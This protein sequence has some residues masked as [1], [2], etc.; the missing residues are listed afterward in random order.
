MSFIKKNIISALGK[1]YNINSESDMNSFDDLWEIFQIGNKYNKVNKD[2][3][4]NSLQ[5]NYKCLIA[6]IL[7][8]DSFE[9]KLNLS[10]ASKKVTIKENVFGKIKSIPD[11]VNTVIFS[12]HHMT[13]NNHRHNYFSKWNKKLYLELLKWYADKDF[14]LIENGDVEE[15]VIFDPALPDNKIVGRYRNLAK[16]NKDIKKIDWCELVNERIKNRIK[17][18]SK[19]VEDNSDYYNLVRDL[20]IKRGTEYYTKISGNHDPYNSG[21]IKNILPSDMGDH[22][23]DALTIKK[24]SGDES[25]FFV[26]HG[27][28]FDEATLPQHAFA[29]GEVYSES[30]G[31]TIQ[32]ADRIWDHNKTERWTNPDL[33]T[34]FF[35]NQLAIG[36]FNLDKRE[37]KNVKIPGTQIPISDAIIEFLSE[38]LLLGHE[39]AWEY[40]DSKT[41]AGAFQEIFSGDEYLKMRHLS[42]T[43][44][45]NT[46][47]NYSN[48]SDLNKLKYIP[49]VIIG[50]TH[51]PRHNSRYANGKIA[52]NYLNTGSAGR[53]INLIWGI[54]IING[55]PNVISWSNYNFIGNKIKL[56]KYHWKPDT[57]GRLLRREVK[58]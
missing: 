57:K 47:N 4:E 32:G 6:A 52:K 30:V 54:E 50:H 21:K 26:T 9:I 46:Y 14:S 39:V 48:I 34:V 31:W 1:A 16:G 45:V 8:T 42:E 17:I 40:F 28:Q 56:K 7:N 27:H 10:G 36:K 23:Y 20:F 41:K 11:S 19:I 29:I 43:T 53:F 15:Y 22:I 33:K 5:Y 24:G 2:E 44:L 37:I 58:I 25:S 55:N 13:F 3:I 51:E 38:E 12:D 49:K 35:N 18:L